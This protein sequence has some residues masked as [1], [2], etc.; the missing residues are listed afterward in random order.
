MK[1][2]AALLSLCL[3]D[4]NT[5]AQQLASETTISHLE[6]VATFPG[7]MPTG[8][9][10]SKEGRIFVNFPRWGDQVDQTVAEVKNGEVIPYP[11][12]A[13]NH[14]SNGD[15]QE[16]KLVSVQSV[17]VDP[18]DR[19]WILDTGAPNMGPTSYGGPKLIA[20]DLNAD[21]IVKKIV[22]PQDVALT[23]S[24][25][26]DVRFDLR[27]GRE[28]MAF[29]TDSSAQ[30]PGIIVVD[31]ATGKA[32]RRLGGD[33]STHPDPN[34]VP[35]LEGELFANV[36]NGKAVA[37][38][39]AGSDGIAVSADGKTLY[40]CPLS[41]RH[42]YSVN[43]DALADQG[44]PEDDVA[45]TV[46]DLGEKGGASDGLE[47][48]AEGRVYLSDYEHDSIHRRNRTGEIETLVHDPRVL[49]PDTLSLGPDHYLYFTANQ[50]HRQPQFHGGKDLRQKPYV[51]FRV[52]VDGTRISQ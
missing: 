8:V 20:V 21:R 25:L 22:F 36:E 10:I 50:L 19:L 39:K 12:A 52:K 32:W 16:D 27:R 48:D 4:L 13:V 3:F 45:A 24:Y 51:L 17:V 30:T 35:V 23:T 7:P 47:S 29:I 2:L 43:V 18:H 44:K 6:I 31:L 34:F 14:Y 33:P 42:L 11:D 40:Y 5:I 1:V 49:W 46:K 26:N 15:K 41:S 9:T 37:R 28:G 38:L